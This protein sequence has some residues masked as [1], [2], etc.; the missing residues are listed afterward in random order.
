[1]RTI[2]AC[3]FNPRFRRRVSWAST[4]R[5][6]QERPARSPLPGRHDGF[7]EAPCDH[8][9]SLIEGLAIV[10]VEVTLEDPERIDSVDQDFESLGRLYDLDG[11]RSALGQN[12]TNSLVRRLRA[13]RRRVA[14]IRGPEGDDVPIEEAERGRRRCRLGGSG[15]HAGRLGRKRGIAVAGK[16]HHG[17]RDGQYDNEPQCMPHLPTSPLSY[18]PPAA[19]RAWRAIWPKAIAWW[20]AMVPEP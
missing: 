16:G 8:N 1:M 4:R 15:R 13:R 7:V 14:N 6:I 17:R 11:A 20:G 2:P 12:L 18:W 5:L 9:R 10:G 19:D 3:S